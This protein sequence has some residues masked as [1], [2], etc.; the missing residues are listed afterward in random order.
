V[1][2]FIQFSNQNA[3]C[4]NVANCR[5]SKD[6][7]LSEHTLLPGSDTRCRVARS[8]RN[9]APESY[10]IWCKD[11]QVALL[12]PL[13]QHLYQIHATSPLYNSEVPLDAAD[14]PRGGGGAAQRL[15]IYCTQL[16][17]VSATYPGHPQGSTGWVDVYNVCGNVSWI[18][19]KNQNQLVTLYCFL[20]A[21]RSATCFGQIYCLSSGSH[22]RR[23]FNLELCRVVVFTVIK[24]ISIGL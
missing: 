18:C 21:V 9:L 8:G 20:L 7:L 16:L 5:V 23:S 15:F 11:E 13:G 10:V 1:V 3:V 4:Q 12:H 14:P 24:I 6:T 17:H 22:M 19:T 2:S